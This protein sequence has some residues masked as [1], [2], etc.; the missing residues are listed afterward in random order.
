MKKRLFLVFIP[1]LFA[2]NSK[3]GSGEDAKEPEVHTRTPVEL[4]EVSYNPLSESIILNAVSSFIRKNEV[5]SISVGYINKMPIQLGDLVHR[6]QILFDLKTKEA[7]A[8]GNNLFPKDTSLRFSGIL[9]IKASREGYIT[10]IHHQIGDF[11]Q[12]GDSLCTI[13]DRSSL[14]FLINVPFEWSRYVHI[15]MH[16]SLILPD[17]RKIPGTLY[18]KVS[19]MDLN[20]QTQNY[21][22]KIQSGENLPENLIAKVEISRENKK[23][24]LSVQKTA[25]LSNEEETRFWVMKVI[26]DS[27][28]IK[29]PIEKGI[30]NSERVEILGNSLKPGDKVIVSGN[31]GLSDSS[32]VFIQK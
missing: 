20:S 16:C 13:V 18:Q 6:G 31:Y 27:M 29:I 22:V 10:S 25:V 1:F 32:K 23:S 26:G 4:S 2:C 12:E 17:G 3:S 8:L 5:R 11:V 15:G 9:P 14:V 24:A 21:M 19:I 30:E 7:N 28:A